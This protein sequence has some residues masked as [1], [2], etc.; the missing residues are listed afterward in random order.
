M[1]KRDRVFCDNL[2]DYKILKEET[3][4]FKRENTNSSIFIIAMALGFKEGKIH[5]TPLK[6]G[7]EGVV[8]LT[9][10][11]EEHLSMIKA[12]AIMDSGL[13]VLFDEDKV[14]SI[15]EEYA[16][17]GIKMLKRELI[18]NKEPGSYIKKLCTELLDISRKIA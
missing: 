18:A 7:K 14:Y 3:E 2:K 6:K 11:K 4:L 5:K 9:Y 13:D 1:K 17:G 8:R 12:V 10:F 15:A 16:N